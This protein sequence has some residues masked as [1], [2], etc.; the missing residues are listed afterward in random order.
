LRSKES[1]IAELESLVHLAKVGKAAGA[2]D[3]EHMD[4]WAAAFTYIRVSNLV[5]SLLEDGEISTPVLDWG[6]GY[7]QVTW[8]LQ[9]RGVPVVSYDV[10]RRPARERM[11]PLNS[12]NVEYG[13]D[14]V[15]LPYASSS[16]G[17]VLSVGVLEHV[18]DMSG[19]L[20]EI[21]RV[22]RPGGLFF[23]FMLPNR[24]SWA[25]WIADRRH[26][27]AHP[28]K[29]TFQAATSL[30]ISHGFDIERRWKRNFLP[31]NLTGFGPRFK[32]AYGSL[33]RQIEMIDGILANIPPTSYLS[34]VLEFVA[35]KHD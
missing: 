31:K 25:E 23:I 26:A 29:F 17:V 16:A 34:G 35:R 7:G 6:C 15:R 12:I 5:A 18:P 20:Q 2:R 9:R 32:R 14:P 33:Y 8:L 4:G 3:L 19:S 13:T 10:E 22:L 30:L 21:N 27:S 28:L 24:Y 11:A 1:E